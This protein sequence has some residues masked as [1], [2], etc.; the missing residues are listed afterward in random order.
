MFLT[1]LGTTPS[2]TAW[3]LVLEPC[4]GPPLHC[5]A[6]R[7]ALVLVCEEPTGGYGRSSTL[8]DMGGALHYQ[9]YYARWSGLTNGEQER[10][11]Q[12][13]GLWHLTVHTSRTVFQWNSNAPKVTCHPPANARGRSSPPSFLQRINV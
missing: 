7:T 1:E 4:C 5:L 6:I 8:P 2:R 10:G 11:V 13:V 3:S 9:G 12:S